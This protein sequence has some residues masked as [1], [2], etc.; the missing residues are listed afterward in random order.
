MKWPLKK[1]PPQLAQKQRSPSGATT[2]LVQYGYNRVQEIVSG[3][4]PTL[5]I[6]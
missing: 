5:N 2:G 6:Q 4:C 1:R 3:Y